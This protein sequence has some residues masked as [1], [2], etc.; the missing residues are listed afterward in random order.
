M[1]GDS[2][3]GI[4]GTVAVGDRDS[5]GAYSW[6]SAQGLGQQAGVL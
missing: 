3:D 6:D 5:G 1:D 2:G 4:A